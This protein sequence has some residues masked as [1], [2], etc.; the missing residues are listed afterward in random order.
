VDKK[1]KLAYYLSHPIQYFSPLLR[2]LAEK[3]D[4]N[5]YY[6]SDSSIKG[7]MDAGF[8]Q[9]IKW[10]VPLLQGYKSRFIRNF[11]F[12]RSMNNRFLDA[13]NPGV[14]GMIFKDKAGVIIVNGWS[15][16]STLL[17]I[18][19]GKIAGKQIWLRAE[20]PLNQESRKS[21]K[22]I[23]LKKLLLEKLLFRIF[24]DRFLYIGTESKKFFQFYGVPEKKLLYTPYA[25]D[26][27]FFQG[28][29]LKYKDDLP[30][31]KTGLHL[32]IEKKVLLFT[33]KYIAKKRPMDLLKVFIE[34]NSP[35]WQLIM[36]GE[37]ELRTEM[38]A[39]IREN[40]AGNVLLTGFVNQSVIPRYYAVADIF[41]M[42]SGV[43]ETWG[44]AVN[45]A[46]NFA[47]PIVVS[48]TCGCSV[49]LVREGVN[50]FV[51]GEGDLPA[52]KAALLKAMKSE[53]D[54]RRMGE[55]SAV[56]VSEFSIASIVGNMS[57]AL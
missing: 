37:G 16:F 48:A 5:V 38:E 19:T 4:L 23:F 39:F 32:P 51:F 49:D 13:V 44:L 41:V 3:T 47:K 46:M 50:G 57:K 27:A 2:S 43:G 53:D 14:I 10:D 52:L 45:E 8:G 18:V 6:F 17:A 15:Y 20:N 7:T 21:R 55:A 35:D 40:N 12:G 34:I 26:N 22:I 56:I 42:C 11:S 28:E 33:G 31:L 30:A 29:F 9:K 36:V 24:V 25:V 54:R 1:I